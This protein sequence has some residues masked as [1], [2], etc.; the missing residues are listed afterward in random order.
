MGVDNGLLAG[1]GLEEG[2]VGA[3][4]HE[5]GFCEDSR[6]KSVLQDV[7]ASFLVGISIGPIE[8][9]TVA[10]EILEGCV[11]ETGGELVRGSLTFRG[12][13]APAACLSP[14][15]AVSVGVEVD[16]DAEGVPGSVNK[17]PGID[18]PASFFKGDVVIFRNEEFGIVAE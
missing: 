15:A 6:A 14:A 11:A 17:A 9:H 13:D 8:A 16:A 10:G 3:V 12:V 2:E 18:S 7:E 1:A 4:V 5:E